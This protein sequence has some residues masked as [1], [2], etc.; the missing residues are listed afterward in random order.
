MKKISLFIAFVLSVQI[1]AQEKVTLRANYKKGDK[2]TVQMN[3]GMTSIG[4]MLNNN[5]TMEQEVT[6]FSNGVY[7]MTSKIS[8]ISMNMMRGEMKASYDSA[9]KDEDLDQRGKQIKQQFAPAFKL[10]IISKNNVYGK[11]ISIDVKPSSSPLA[12][13]Y[14]NQLNNSV[15]FPEKAVGVG[16][17]WQTKINANGLKTNITYTVKSIS[18][19]EVIVE[20]NGKTSG[21][22]EGVSKGS[23]TIDRT[24]GI[25]VKSKIN[26]VEKAE[27]QEA[28]TTVE[29]I[30]TKK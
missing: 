2:F 29:T 24:L 26:I 3:F 21:I 17:T 28:K 5:T 11:V 10:A 8:K 18:L 9:A 1:L 19:K 20:I 16:D 22:A 25:P 27:G 12:I 23:M 30:I 13:Q 15:A 4:A 14:K 6:D 7:T